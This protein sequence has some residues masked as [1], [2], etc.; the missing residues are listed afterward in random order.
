M[1]RYFLEVSYK[2]TAYSGFQTQENANTIQAEVEKAF[3]ILQRDKVV[4]T[5]SSRTDA[6][7]HA[8]QNFF[9]F[10]YNRIIHP[11]FLYKV[12]AILPA[13]IVI[14]GLNQVKDN[15]HC[16]FDAINREYKY[17]IYRRKDPFLEDRAFFYPYKLDMEL[18]EKAAAII[19]E[20]HD[21][22]SFSK[23]NTQVKTFS[24]DI[25]ESQWLQEGDCLVY[26][27][28][29]NRFLRGMV[30][31]L[32]A[33]MLKLGRGKL[34]LDEFRAV[35]DA[36]DCTKASFAVPAHGLFLVS[37][38]YPQNKEQGSSKKIIG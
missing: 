2:G 35:I 6:G 31:A 25:I 17:F 32:T 3:E 4:M 24:C 28:K 12:N 19:K 9:H 14:Q 27:V 37:V 30:R 33:T 29:G 7:V 10:D 36:K 38:N 16:R 5:G 18:L 1:P 15:A 11:Q 8:L 22:T 26:N 23:R 34:S 20:Y 13:D 21:F